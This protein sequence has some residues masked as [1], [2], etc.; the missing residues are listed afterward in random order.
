MSQMRQ[1]IRNHLRKSASSAGARL[2]RALAAVLLALAACAPPPPPLDGAPTFEAGPGWRVVQDGLWQMD[3]TA[4]PDDSPL[5]EPLTVFRISPEQFTFRVRYTP[6]S[7]QFVSAWAAQEPEAALV[8]NAGFFD[9]Q[10]RATALIVADGAAY[11]SSYRDFG[12]M[13]GVQGGEAFLR[14]LAR[15]PL[16]PGEVFEQA[17]QSAPLLLAADGSIYSGSD[18]SPARRTVLARSRSGDIVLI[19]APGGGFSL[20]A[21]ARWLADSDLDLEIALNLDGGSS[22]GY[23]GPSGGVDSYAPV[24]AVVSVQSK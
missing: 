20:P 2:A 23:W 4:Q 10:Y 14:S 9:E 21:L 12:G 16:L 5:P 3:T 19:V 24:P 15:E 13:F 8:F 22:T 1:M 18:L 6:G 11:G 7:P 17:I